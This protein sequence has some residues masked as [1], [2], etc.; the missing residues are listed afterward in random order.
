MQ[1]LVVAQ[2]AGIKEKTGFFQLG[3]GVK[4]LDR[5]GDGGVCLGGRH[6]A[7]GGVDHLRVVTGPAGDN[8]VV[9]EVVVAG[10]QVYRFGHPVG[11]GVVAQQGLQIGSLFGSRVQA[12]LAA[13]CMHGYQHGHFAFLGALQAGEGH[14][15]GQL[16]AGLVKVQHIVGNGVV[17][18]LAVLVD[19]GVVLVPLVVLYL[20]HRYGDRV[21]G[22]HFFGQVCFNGALYIYILIIGVNVCIMTK[23][24]VAVH[25]AVLDHRQSVAGDVE[26]GVV[27]LGQQLVCRA[28]QL[29]GDHIVVVFQRGVCGVKGLADGGIAL[30]ADGVAVLTEDDGIVPLFVRQDRVAIGAGSA[31]FVQSHRGVLRGGVEPHLVLGV[32]Q[33]Y[34]DLAALAGCDGKA[35]AG[36]LAAALVGGG[37]GVVTCGQQVVVGV[38]AV[39]VLLAGHGLAVLVLHL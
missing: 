26:Q 4:G 29:N 21:V 2:G 9:A 25:A 6:G 13:V 39:L 19:H 30:G 22:L 27:R 11:C 8:A 10:G 20:V 23:V 35:A 34:R 32:G 38:V 31:V 24:R 36:G 5:Q 12:L 3:G 17:V 28:F 33:L 18:D 14:G 16:C 37:V 7:G 1:A 15:D